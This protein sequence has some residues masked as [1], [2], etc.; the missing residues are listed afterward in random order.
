VGELSKGLSRRIGQLLV[1]GCEYIADQ[2]NYY[3]HASQVNVNEVGDSQRK[4]IVASSYG[5]GKIEYR[6]IC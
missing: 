6:V 5:L 4:D 1:T 2:I 3:K